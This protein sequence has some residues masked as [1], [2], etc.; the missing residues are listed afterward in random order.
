MRRLRDVID[1]LVIYTG[2]VLVLGMMLFT[3]AS[4]WQTL[5][6]LFGL[7][8]VQLGVWRVASALLP[9]SRRNQPLRDEVDQ[10]IKLVRE[11][12]RVANAD[13]PSA[14]EAVSY[15]LRARTEGVIEAAKADLPL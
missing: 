10:F 4:V 13:Q 11:M 8:L 6:V 14:F 1:R 12:Y 9:N 5:L 2:V 15:E 7:L 3:E